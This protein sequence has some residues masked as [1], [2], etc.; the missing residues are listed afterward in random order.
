MEA[1]KFEDRSCRLN[2]GDSDN[3]GLANI[4]WNETRSRW[5]NGSFRPL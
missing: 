3:G 5:C 1:G 2:G 4:D